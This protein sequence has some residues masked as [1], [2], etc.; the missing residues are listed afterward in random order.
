MADVADPPT[1]SIKAARSKVAVSAKATRKPSAPKTAKSTKS[2]KVNKVKTE[3]P[4]TLKSPQF[5]S[6]AVPRV[7][8]PKSAVDHP[9]YLVMIVEAI[10]K[11]DDRRGASHQAIHKNINTNYNLDAKLSRT[12][13]SAAL[14]KGVTSGALIQTSGSGASGRF[15]VGAP[16]RA[17]AASKSDSTKSGSISKTTSATMSTKSTKSAT[18]SVSVKKSKKTP[19][20][21]KKEPSKSKKPS[22]KNQKA[23]SKKTMKPKKV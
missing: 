9:S 3:F 22:T 5:Q 17:T 4:I 11:I 7:Q 15:K 10:K 8:K 19:A 14:K 1:V 23:P 2:A 6:N 20:K 16:K 13:I 18:K 21:S 12:H